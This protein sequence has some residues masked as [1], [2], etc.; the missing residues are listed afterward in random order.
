LVNGKAR[1]YGNALISTEEVTSLDLNW[2][3]DGKVMIVRELKIKPVPAVSGEETIKS[4]QI[5]DE[6]TVLSLE[7]TDK[8]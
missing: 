6:K 1:V 4:R 5:T 3:E 8:V 2:S 7:C